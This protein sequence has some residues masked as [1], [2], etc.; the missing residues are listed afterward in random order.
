[1]LTSISYRF[2]VIC[3]QELDYNQKNQERVPMV[4]NSPDS[5]SNNPDSGSSCAAASIGSCNDLSTWITRRRRELDAEIRRLLQAGDLDAPLWMQLIAENNRLQ[6]AQF[7]IIEHRDYWAAV[8][9]AEE[10]LGGV[11]NRYIEH[12]LACQR[13]QVF[14]AR[15]EQLCTDYRYAIFLAVEAYRGACTELQENI[16]DLAMEYSV[17]IDRSMWETQA[18]TN[19]AEEIDRVF[20]QGA[21]AQDRS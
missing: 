18:W 16:R 3:L 9:E 8:K 4:S 7:R 11:A 5:S 6:R 1:M 12:R 2:V 17:A 10:Y 21:N 20:D 14:G 15:A 13:G 19:I